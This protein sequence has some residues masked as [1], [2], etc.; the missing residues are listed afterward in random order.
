MT[1]TKR[2]LATVLALLVPAGA[3]AAVELDTFQAGETVSAQ[4]I[5]DNFAALKAELD[6]Q[7]TQIAT[8]QA[9]NES[10]TSQLASLGQWRTEG[11]AAVIDGPV[12][13]GT[14]AP[15]AALQVTG[16]VIINSP[17][18]A[19]AA[20]LLR[21]NAHDATGDFG[22]SF[23]RG[24][25]QYLELGNTSAGLGA[26]FLTGTVRIKSLANAQAGDAYV[27]VNSLGDLKR[28]DSPCL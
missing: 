7:A 1:K 27:C 10:L 21:H 6:A 11:D 23:R 24:E 3:I 9:Q 8:L 17:D 28:S 19:T 26:H 15:G 14:D 5:N 22:L 4:R 16:D 13:I 2:M 20:W 12:G 18:S 25:T